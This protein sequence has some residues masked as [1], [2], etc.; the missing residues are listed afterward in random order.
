MDVSNFRQFPGLVFV[1][2][3]MMLHLCEQFN[4][5][6]L[7]IESLNKKSRCDPI[8]YTLD[9]KEMTSEAIREQ[10]PVMLKNLNDTLEFL[11]LKGPKDWSNKDTTR[12]HLSVPKNLTGV[13]VVIYH[14]YD[15]AYSR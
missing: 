1:G 14:D 5:T 4:F 7:D 12:F 13:W 15:E 11:L 2:Q 8:S 6:T 9:G 3:D 10:M